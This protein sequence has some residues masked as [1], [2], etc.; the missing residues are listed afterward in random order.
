[1]AGVR[2]SMGSPPPSPGRL[3]QRHARGSLLAVLLIT[4]LLALPLLQQPLR[5]DTQLSRFFPDDEVA[6]AQQRVVDH[7]GQRYVV[8]TVLVEGTDVLSPQ[9]LRTTQAAVVALGHISGVQQV[10]SLSTVVDSLCALQPGPDGGLVTVPGRTIA[11]CTDPELRTLRDS[12]LLPF[13]RGTIDER[14][15]NASGRSSAQLQQL[16]ILLLT[17]LPASDGTDPLAHWPS[18]SS[19]L[20]VVQVDYTL[21]DTQLTRTSLRLQQVTAQL[22]PGT[23]TF[24]HTDAA[25][26]SHTM[27]V[28]TDRE[29]P[30]L[31]GGVLLLMV[32]VLLLTFRQA[33]YVLLP[34]LTLALGLLWTVGTAMWLGLTLNALDIAVFP[35]IVGLGIDYSIYLTLR[36]R[37][38]LPQMRSPQRAL[39]HAVDDQWVALLL[40]VVT[41]VGAFLT[42]LT[43][44]LPPIREFGLLAGLGIGYVF[45]LTL[46]FHLPVRALL[47]R[48]GARTAVVEERRRPVLARTLALGAKG[49]YRAP[50][51]VALAVVLL[52]SGAM[53]AATQL[54]QDFSVR[55]FVPSDTPELVTADR[56]ATSFPAASFAEGYLLLEGTVA[57]IEGYSAVAQMSANV[58]DDEGVVVVVADGVSVPAI[59]SVSTWAAAAAAADPTLLERFHLRADGGPQP[60]MGDSDV[61]GLFDLLWSTDEPSAGPLLHRHGSTYDAA[62]VRVLIDAADAPAA[63]RLVSQLREDRV[64]FGGGSVVVTGSVVLTVTTLDAMAASQVWSTIESLA[65]SGV[66]LVYWHGRS[67]RPLLGVLALAPV[68][69][70]TLWVLGTMWLVRIPLNV[71][72]LTITALIIGMG[73]DYSIHIIERYLQEVKRT[74]PRIAMRT[75]I[76]RTGAAVILSAATTVLGFGTLLLTPL[77]LTQTFGL[78]SSVAIVYVTI[79]AALV[80]PVALLAWSVGL[81]RPP[82]RGARPRHEGAP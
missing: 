37:E 8:H 40:S 9:G 14:M 73:I 12:V 44:T 16:R 54:H 81:L 1:M 46:F 35:L 30:L 76:E 71:L 62:V 33:S 39:A 50:V 74:P 47:D 5:I 6:H 56:I 26:L 31:I 28:A 67:G 52:T 63:R 60:Q 42:N 82:R 78:I 69:V 65:L 72:T 21:S 66:L 36:Y 25:L 34:L 64:P 77:P 18:A 51:L 57:T 38:L 11:N 23:V 70:A 41:T 80:L 10:L 68:A 15:V 20:V 27:D 13:L 53:V 61:I 22:P 19:T 7:F 58:A 49:M 4:V 55:D 59:R 29:A 48:R 2:R 32:T 79:L 24:R 3:V 17:L 43:S 75:T 45:L